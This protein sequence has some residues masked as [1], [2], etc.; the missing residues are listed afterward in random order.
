MGHSL[1]GYTALNTINIHPFI[2]KAIII[3]GF[4]DVVSELKGVSHINIGFLF[5]D[6]RRY[7]KIVNKEYYGINNMKYLKE[8]ND[9]ILFIHSTDD[10]M[11]PYK[12]ATE[13]IYKKYKDKF[14]FV[15]VS[16]KDHNPNYTLDALKYM[17]ETFGELNSLISSG[18]VKTTEEKANYMKDKSLLKM[19]EQDSEVF[20]KIF[21]FIES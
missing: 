13:R 4:I 2:K 5:N 1:G 14:S 16:G 15:I 12:Y 6:V 9:S 17:K 10:S 11:V 3:S 8:T 7:E 21:N 18:E 20:S 19:T